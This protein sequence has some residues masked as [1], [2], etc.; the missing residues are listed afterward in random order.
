MLSHHLALSKLEQTPNKEFN[1]GSPFHWLLSLQMNH[2]LDS[3]VFK[4]SF[5]KIMK[6]YLKQPVNM[7]QFCS[8]ASLLTLE[9]N[10]L[11]SFT[12]LA[13]KK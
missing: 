11:L 7:A 1:K 13:L 3:L 6:T 9:K 10:G 4:N 5:S 12:R 8:V 2:T